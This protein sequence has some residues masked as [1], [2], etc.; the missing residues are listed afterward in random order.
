VSDSYLRLIPEDPLFVPAGGAMERARDL[1]ERMVPDAEEVTASLHEDPVFVDAGGNAERIAC[2][3]CDADIG[4]T[5]WTK[6]MYDPHRS[7]F[8]RLEV[9]TPCCGNDVSLN[10]LRSEWPAGFAR[11]VLEA[12]NPNVTRLDAN[13]VSEL[14]ETLGAPLRIIWAHY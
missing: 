2:P 1:L 13:E 7:A 3:F 8:R 12:W 14:E 10:D 5:W 9:V 4:A 6:A 11:L